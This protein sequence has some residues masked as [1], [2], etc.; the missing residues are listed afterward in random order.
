AIIFA[1]VLA[2]LF[3]P[4]ALPVLPP[5]ALARHPLQNINYN[6]GEEVGW[7][8]LTATVAHVYHSLPPAERATT[9]ILTGNYGEAG[10]IDRYGPALGLPNAYSG[11]NSFWWWG[12]PRPA[13]TT[14]IVVGLTDTPRY[15]ERYFTDVRRVATIHN[16]YRVD[17]DEEGMPVWLCRGQKQPWAA[18]WPQFKNYG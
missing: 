14:T 6:L 15:L 5:S 3:M 12:P 16:R 2:A 1:V 7:P 11:H 10:A 8:E 17:N 13:R 4:V 9:V 18:I